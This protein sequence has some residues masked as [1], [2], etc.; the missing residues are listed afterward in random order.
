M[1]RCGWVSMTR[2][3]EVGWRRLAGR[4]WVS[5][6]GWAMN[7]VAKGQAWIIGLTGM[8]ACTS[9]WTLP[10]RISEYSQGNIL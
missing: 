5:A 6:V 8:T 3:D 9:G 7:G 2:S 4:D 1:V 10:E